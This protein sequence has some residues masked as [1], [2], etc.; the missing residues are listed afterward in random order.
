[1]FYF[2]FV[3][4]CDSSCRVFFLISLFLIVFSVFFVSL[5]FLLKSTFFVEAGLLRV[6]TL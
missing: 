4:F 2:Y 3:F 1:M 5:V 6:V